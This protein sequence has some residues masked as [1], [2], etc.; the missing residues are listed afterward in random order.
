MQGIITGH[1]HDTDN[2]DTNNGYSGN[3][4]CSTEEHHHEG[5][6]E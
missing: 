4:G 3:N 6:H 2:T 5:N 1:G